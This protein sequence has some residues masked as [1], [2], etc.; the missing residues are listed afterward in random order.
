[1]SN[2]KIPRPS[3]SFDRQKSDSSMETADNQ[4]D[5]QENPVFL[6]EKDPWESLLVPMEPNPNLYSSFEGSF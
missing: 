2:P 4:E 1:M 6:F 5:I 3:S